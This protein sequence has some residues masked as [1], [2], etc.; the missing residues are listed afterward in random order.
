MKKKYSKNYNPRKKEYV[1]D[2]ETTKRI[3]NCMKLIRVMKVTNNSAYKAMFAHFITGAPVNTT[4]DGEFTTVHLPSNKLF[5]ECYGEVQVIFKG[6]GTKRY[7]L[8]DVRP[9]KY[10]EDCFS[11]MPINY[12]GLM[13]PN[14]PKDK[15]KVQ[16]NYNKL[17]K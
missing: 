17:N 6:E 10:L 16:F 4:F 15:F 9:R 2:F 5:E 1:A 3:N 7:N 14:N 8:Y 11:G 13:I 12:C